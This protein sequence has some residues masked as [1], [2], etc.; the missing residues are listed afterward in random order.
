MHNTFVTKLIA[1]VTSISKYSSGFW[2]S[3]V[4]SNRQFW[5]TTKATIKDIC[6][7]WKHFGNFFNVKFFLKINFIGSS[8]SN[9]LTS[10][11][12]HSSK[13]LLGVTTSHI[14]PKPVNYHYCKM[15]QGL[16]DVLAILWRNWTVL[17]HNS[18]QLFQSTGGISIRIN[19][20][21]KHGPWHGCSTSAQ[22]QRAQRERFPP[23]GRSKLLS[24]P[25]TLCHSLS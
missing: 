3:C 21:N 20:H 1:W 6:L 9:K 19:F 10:S 4:L 2:N 16:T 8:T 5:I 11:L 25:I 24:Q 23:L 7:S 15:F 14:P 22:L 17:G 18:P 12:I 13:S